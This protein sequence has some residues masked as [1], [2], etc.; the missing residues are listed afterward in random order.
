M[1]PLGRLTARQERELA[2]R[3]EQVGTVLEARAEPIIG[4]VT[5]GAHA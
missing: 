3:V 5:V 2:T 4:E 1:E